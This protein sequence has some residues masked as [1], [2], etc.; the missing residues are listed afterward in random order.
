MA[1]AVTSTTKR[2]SCISG[3]TS[4]LVQRQGWVQ[5]IGRCPVDRHRQPDRGRGRGKAGWWM[6]C[7][8]RAAE[9]GRIAHAG[10]VLPAPRK[11]FWPA[12]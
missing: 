11:R 3:F 7:F 8:L 12:G 4:A 10:P 6:R 5:P 9:P 2:T 1:A